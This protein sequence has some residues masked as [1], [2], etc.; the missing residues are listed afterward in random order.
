L[1]NWRTGGFSSRAQ[2]HGVT[3]QYLSQLLLTPWFSLFFVRMVNRLQH[4][5]WAASFFFLS[6]ISWGGVRLSS[7]GTS[8]TNWPIVPVPHVRWVWSIL[9]NENCQKT[10]NYSEKT[11]PSVTLS[12]TNP[13]WPESGSDPDSRSEKL[14]TELWHG[15]G[16]KLNIERKLLLWLCKRCNIAR[17]WL[18]LGL[19]EWLTITLLNSLAFI[20]TNGTGRQV[21]MSDEKVIWIR[22]C[23]LFQSS[24]LPELQN[25]HLQKQ[26]ENWMIIEA[27]V[28]TSLNSLIAVRFP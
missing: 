6:L 13:T 26:V 19:N 23:R 11:C 4:F 1:S 20:A 10:P 12:T 22:H 28:A 18:S 14:A 9:W 16:G 27:W 2:H 8:G 3:L 17:L 7:P 25:G 21:I 24:I 5:A 15:P